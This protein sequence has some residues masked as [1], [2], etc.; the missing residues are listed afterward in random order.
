[1]V[2]AEPTY[3]RGAFSAFNAENWGESPMTETPQTT[4]NAMNNGSS[5]LKNKGESAQQIPEIS[6]WVA[7]TQAL[8]TFFDTMPP[9]AHPMNPAAMIAKDHMGTFKTVPLFSA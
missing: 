8:P 9:P 7:A 5:A 1:M 3:S 2:R 6:S 4:R